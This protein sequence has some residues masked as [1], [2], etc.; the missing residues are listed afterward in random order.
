MGQRGPARKANSE[1][2]AKGDPG[3]RAKR[4]AAAEEATICDTTV[5]VMTPVM[6]K[7]LITE[8]VKHWN[9]LVPQ[10]KAA[11]VIRAIDVDLLADY[12]QCMGKAIKYETYCKRYGDFIQK[13]PATKTLRP[14]VKLIRDLRKEAS[15]LADKLGLTPSSRARMNITIKQ[16]PSAQQA[17]EDADIAAITNRRKG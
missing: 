14:E 13:S 17:A 16:P 9:Y 7:Y 10:L 6:P 12:C 5:D 2:I 4:R 11:G 8:A 3:K 1:Q 15:R